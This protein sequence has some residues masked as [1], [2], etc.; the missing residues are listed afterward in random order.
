MDDPARS[1][2]E[3]PNGLL[4]VHL[5]TPSALVTAYNS[6]IDFGLTP[7]PADMQGLHTP[8]CM[9]LLCLQTLP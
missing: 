5:D 7:Y 2:D 3:D 6:S 8:V 9:G 4:L 1:C